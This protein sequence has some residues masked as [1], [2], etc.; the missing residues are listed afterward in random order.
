MLKTRPKQIYSET[1]LNIFY[2]T[3]Y[4]NEKVNCAEPSP[5]VSIPWVKFVH[6]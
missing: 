4:L 6:D 1:T 5:L 3:S 2:K